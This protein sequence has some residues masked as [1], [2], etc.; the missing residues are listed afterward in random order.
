[1]E[2]KNESLAQLYV[3]C[4]AWSVL[5]LST[6][7]SQKKNDLNHIKNNSQMIWLALLRDI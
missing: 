1:M 2:K 4:L 5:I 3:F 6:F 7:F